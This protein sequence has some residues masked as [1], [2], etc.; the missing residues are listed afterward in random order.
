MRILWLLT[1]WI[2]ASQQSVR[3]KWLTDITYTTTTEGWLYLAVA[4]DVYSRKVVG[5][6][7]DKHIEQGLVASRPYGWLLPTG[8]Q[9]SIC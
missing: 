2:A 7:M 6:A 9:H 8:Y 1:C 5:W 4:L 3:K